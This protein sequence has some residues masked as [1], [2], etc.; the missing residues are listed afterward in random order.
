M[1]I[2]AAC[3]V[4]LSFA[5]T[6]FSAPIA[7]P[8]DRALISDASILTARDPNGTAL[9]SKRTS[10]AWSGGV[11]EGLDLK[12]VTGTFILPT[13]TDTTHFDLNGNQTFGI[14][15]GIDGSAGEGCGGLL[16]AG[17]F[18]DTFAGLATYK[19]F[20]EWISD[21]PIHEH[22]QLNLS[23]GDSV[24]VTVTA[25]SDTSGSALIENNSKGTAFLLPYANQT[26]LCQ[27]YTADWI[28]ERPRAHF[29]G[30]DNFHLTPL[31]DFGTITFT[32]ASA[33]TTDGRQIDASD[34]RLQLMDMDISGG[35]LRLT[36]A[37]M[38]DSS[39]VVTYVGNGKI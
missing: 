35:D 5:S 39:F 9:G 20:Y 14:W 4:G 33:T 21:L 8:Y 12:T 24:T 19:P 31:V 27:P 10:S 36:N 38:D 26:K 28:V 17:V 13:I 23:G 22:A 29:P 34:A 3:L 1:N 6:A 2:L 7:A 37:T 16:Q 30:F 18:L 15:V 25:T 32:G 11:I